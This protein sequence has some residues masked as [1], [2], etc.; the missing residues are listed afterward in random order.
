MEMDDKTQA[1]IHSANEVI[2]KSKEVVETFHRLTDAVV[3]KC[4]DCKHPKPTMDICYQC[5]RRWPITRGG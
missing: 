3:F 1:I 5:F 2:K 4:R